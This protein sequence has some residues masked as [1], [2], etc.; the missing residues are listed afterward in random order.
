MKTEQLKLF[1]DLYIK[2]NKRCEYICHTLLKDLNNYRFMSHFDLDT[3]SNEVD[4]YGQDRDWFGAGEEH[5]EWFPS[6]FIYKSD[7]EILKW[8]NEILEKQRKEKEEKEKIR[9]QRELDCEYQR[10]LELK[11]K[12]EK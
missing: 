5:Y 12:F 8:K 4:C 3:D 6:D 1:S 2:F 11:R 9:Q 7:E 10:Y